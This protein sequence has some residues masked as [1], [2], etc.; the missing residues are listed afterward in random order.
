[1]QNELYRTNMA[2]EIL[3]DDGNETTILD[4]MRK[5]VWD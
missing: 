3:I 5:I 1:M 4:A 2:E